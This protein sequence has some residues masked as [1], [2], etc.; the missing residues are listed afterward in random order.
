MPPVS[1]SDEDSARESME[2][3]RLEVMQCEKE[4]QSIKDSL[5]SLNIGAGSEDGS[6]NTL[7]VSVHKVTYSGEGPT[8]EGAPSTF[9]V[10]VS[11]PI[12]ER[13]ITK[14]HDPLDPTAEGSF[15]VFESVE[16][17]N[18]LLTI[19]AF[20][21]ADASGGSKLGVSAAHDLLPLCEDMKVMGEGNKSLMVDFA[22]VTEGEE[23]AVADLSTDTEARGEPKK[24]ADE[25]SKSAAEVVDGDDTTEHDSLPVAEENDKDNKDSG[26]KSGD[27]EPAAVQEGE[28]ETYFDAAADESGENK[29][30]NP[31]ADEDVEGEESKDDSYVGLVSPTD[32]TPAAS[33]ET[34]PPQDNITSSSNGETKEPKVQVPFCTLS[35]HLEYTPSL[36]DK[37]DAIY[38]KLNEVSKRKAAAIESLRKSAAAVNRSKAAQE[39]ASDNNEKS[40][41][42]KSGFLNKS[43]A[44][45]SVGKDVPPPLWKR[46]YE[47][48][49][50]PQ[51]MLWVIGP[52]AKNYV[53]F[54]AVS[55]FLHYKGDL[56]ALPPP[57]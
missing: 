4:I 13:T 41:A 20:S 50:G 56:L 43:K 52:V 36:N 32:E 11:S 6:L 54:F 17:S 25:D 57:V 39:S 15:A 38:D 42:V 29:D 16:T 49:I 53:I 26:A 44:S 14:L 40:A 47:K 55:A 23:L 33:E 1:F 12:E 3:S 5:K 46:W 2:T 31:V 45:G 24:T 19:E 27:S 22:I 18:A 34:K 21:I 8:D 37:R 51:S 10:H 48:T 30:M 35:V 28:D 7:K 9:K